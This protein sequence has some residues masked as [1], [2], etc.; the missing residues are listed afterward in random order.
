VPETSDTTIYPQPDTLNVGLRTTQELDA[1]Q[2]ALRVSWVDWDSGFRG[3]GL[4]VAD[5]IVA[6][7]GEPIPKPADARELARLLGTMVGQLGEADRWRKQ[8]AQEGQ[9]VA[10]TVRRRVLPGEGWSTLSIT[11]QLRLRKVHQNAQG[12]RLFGLGGPD[13]M[14]YAEGESE[15]WSSWFERLQRIWQGVLDEG[16]VRRTLISD[17]ELRQHLEAESRLARLE[18]Q[19][20]GPFARAMRA[21]FEAVRQ[22]LRGPTHD[23]G[24]NA[25]SYRQS[26]DAMAYQVA[27]AA[28][29]DRQAFLDARVAEVIAAFPSINPVLGDRAAV[30]GRLV[31]LPLIRNRD[32]I[33]QGPGSCLVFNQGNDWY[34]ADGES[35]ALQKALRARS[36]FE[37][38]LGASVREEFEVIGRIAPDAALVVVEG[39][40][41]FA[42]KVEPVAITLGGQVFVVVEGDQPDPCFSGEAALKVQ[43]RRPPPADAS[44]G[45]VLQASFD[46]SKAGDRTLWDSLFAAFDLGYAPNGLPLV[47]LTGLP[48]MDSR[49]LEAR[50]RWQKDVCAVQLRWVGEV[51]VLVRGDEFDGAPRIEE[52]QIEVDHLRLDADGLA[53]NFGSIGLNRV[54]LLRRV[55]G[56]PWRIATQK[57][58]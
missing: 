50:Q 17:S 33:S 14:G 30:A 19:F 32:W 48:C 56:G 37:Q 53:R 31:Q 20:P 54:W 6:V 2:P 29:S 52:V 12:R 58:I 9:A 40:G 24:P 26:A 34:V 8:G 4:Q 42:L 57:G 41:R 35:R 27:H 3:S 25:L 23:L 7:N 55:D 43:S 10:L 5:R 28:R 36:R 44:P 11:G 39:R 18:A 49:W 45:D 16:W 1:V 15:V 51:Q 47:R 38:A 13:Q 21:D 22:S 46:A